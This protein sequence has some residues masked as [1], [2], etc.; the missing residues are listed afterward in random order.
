MDWFDGESV[1]RRNRNMTEEGVSEANSRSPARGW[2]VALIWILVLGLLG[3]VGFGLFNANRGPLAVGSPAPDFVL[4]TFEGEQIDTAG[5]RGKVVLVNIWASWCV[6]C[7]DEAVELEQA[8]QMFKDRDV[9]FLG[10]DWSDVQSKALAYLDRYGITYPN[11]PDLGQKIYKAYRVR[12]VPETYI[13]DSDGHI[14]GIKIGPYSSLEEIVNA[15]ESAL[16]P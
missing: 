11:G 5:L 10:V 9:V 16:I 14:A 15:V 1:G 2:V 4:E 3:L 6:T 8:Y 7:T 12:G 13:I